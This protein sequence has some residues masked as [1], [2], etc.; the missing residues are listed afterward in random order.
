MKILDLRFDEWPLTLIFCPAYNNGGATPIMT[1]AR[2]PLIFKT[3]RAS[4][5]LLAAGYIG[6]ADPTLRRNLS[7]RLWGPL[8][9]SIPPYDNRAF[10]RR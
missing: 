6:A 4:L 7:L 3:F 10:P 2:K 5:T 1:D 8:I 9:Q